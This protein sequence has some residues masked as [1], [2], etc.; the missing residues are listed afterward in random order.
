[1]N[2]TDK[3]FLEEVK[4]LQDIIKRMASNSFFV[5]GWSI[6]LVTVTLLIK[7]ASEQFYAPLIA[8]IPLFSFWVLDAFFLRQEQLFRKLHDWIIQNR[9]SKREGVR[10]YFDFNTKSFSSEVGSITSLMF[11]VTL[12]WF[13][14]PTLLIIVLF[15]TLNLISK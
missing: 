12:R 9:K 13:Y 8:L 10:E 6:T 2:E 14:I 1:M 5:K 11:S 7:V 4:M 3:L 15:L